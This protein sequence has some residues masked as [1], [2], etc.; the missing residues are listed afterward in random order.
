[1]KAAVKL[2]RRSTLTL[3]ALLLA[4][5][6]ALGFVLLRSAQGDR[7]LVA[8]RDLAAGQLLSPNDFAE[9]TAKLSPAATGY[10]G[11]LPTD[12]VLTQPLRQ[13][14]LLNRGQLA[15]AGAGQLVHLAIDPSSPL[16]TDVRVGSKVS[17]WFIPKP[18]LSA[19]GTSSPATKGSAVAGLVASNIQVLQIT[20][21]T[22]SLGVDKTRLEIEVQPE[23]VAAIIALQ[24]QDGNLSVTAQG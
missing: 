8:T 11:Q 7:V 10:L 13:G 1:M 9:T 19:G 12:S 3:T 2:S 17:L 15:A 22:D 21:N 16:A 4:V 24:A 23:L 18:G 6:L 14:E 5:A 20:K